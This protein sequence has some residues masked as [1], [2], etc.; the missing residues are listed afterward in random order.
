VTTN[1]GRFAE[2]EEALVDDRWTATD[3][4]RPRIMLPAEA[5]PLEHRGRP[6]R[7]GAVVGLSSGTKEGD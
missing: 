1:L 4:T 2:F 6:K 7:Q 3:E 5:S